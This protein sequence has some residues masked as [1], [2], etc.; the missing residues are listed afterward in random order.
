MG[1]FTDADRTDQRENAAETVATVDSALLADAVTE[2]VR[3]GW[4]LSFSSSRDGYALRVSVLRDGERDAAWCEDASQLDKA[5]T[6]L[7]A[8]ATAPSGPPPPKGGKRG[9]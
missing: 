7:V 3:A 9:S 4:M 1:V 5:L 6:A 8:A 2:A